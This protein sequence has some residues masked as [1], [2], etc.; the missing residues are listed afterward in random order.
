MPFQVNPGQ[1][2]HLGETDVATGAIGDEVEVRV[3]DG[4]VVGDRTVG[5]GLLYGIKHLEARDR[6]AVIRGRGRESVGEQ[7]VA[8]GLV[9]RP[10]Q[11]PMNAANVHMQDCSE[12]LHG[13]TPSLAAIARVG[14]DVVALLQLDD[15]RLWR[16]KR[17]Y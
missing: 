3:A 9:W 14:A 1:A 17:R 12:S 16:L 2:V 6:V 4:V 5:R 10:L 15:H 11:A 8:V 7:R 13:I